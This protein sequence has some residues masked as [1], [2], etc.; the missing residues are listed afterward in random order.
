MKP[1]DYLNRAKEYAKSR[2]GECLAQEYISSKTKTHWKCSN[3]EHPMFETDFQ[4][5]SKKSWCVLCYR[6]AL[7][8]KQSLSDGLDK[9]H[10]HAK[11]NEGLCLSTEFKN[12]KTNLTWQCKNN[13]IWESN[14]D[15]AVTRDRWCQQ[16]HYDK[17]ILPDAY[18][19]ITNYAIK[20]NGKAFVLPQDDIKLH[21]IIEF[22]CDNKEHKS[23]HAEFRNIIKGGWCPYCAGKFSAE[24]YLDLAKKHA[25][26]KGGQCL[27]T[28]YENQNTKLEWQCHDS[29][30]KS[31]IRTLGKM[32][33][34]DSWCKQCTHI[35]K[36]PIRDQYLEIAKKHA[37]SKGGECLSSEYIDHK[38][39]LI[40][41][42][43][44]K[45]HSTWEATYGNVVGT[46]NRWCPQCAGQFPSHEMLEKAKN[47]AI[48]RKG[49]CLSNLY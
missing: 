9:A 16:C 26:S 18:E 38:K 10:A 45:S 2:G 12:V 29:S 47:H 42:C 22:K 24:E 44:N 23:W 8:K 40:W 5:I 19:Q 39:K 28:I 13:H 35:Q 27:S 37:I 6:E 20:K 11:K 25:I 32:I 15:H 3:P 34:Y 30:H 17:S 33:E 46:L 21:T 4:I 1:E 36:Q 14:F 48:S 7:S 49:Q 43:K 41:S 31:F